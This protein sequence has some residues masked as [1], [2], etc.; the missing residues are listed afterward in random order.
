MTLPCPDDLLRTDGAHALS[1]SPT[2]T[3]A[4]A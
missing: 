2:A 4:Q 3:I 1:P